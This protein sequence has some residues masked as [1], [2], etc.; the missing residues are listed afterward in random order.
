VTED[1][2]PCPSY[3]QGEKKI[4]GQKVSKPLIQYKADKHLYLLSPETKIL[5]LLRAS[6]YYHS[7]SC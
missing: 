2:F 5:K 4:L 7:Y 1:F 6:W 3:D